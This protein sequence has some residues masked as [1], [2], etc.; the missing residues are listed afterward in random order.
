M[1][2]SILD[3]LLPLA[4]LALGVV[5]CYRVLCWFWSFSIERR[6]RLLL[7]RYDAHEGD[8]CEELEGEG[9]QAVGGGGPPVVRRRARNREAIA[10]SL[11][12]AAYYQ[13]GARPRSEANLLVTRKFMRDQLQEYKDLRAKDGGVIIDLAL[14]MS[15]L[16]SVE[17]RE[18]DDLS[19]TSAFGRRLPVGSLWSRLLGLGSA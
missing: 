19:G 3:S 12:E 13:F 14:P 17:Y 10:F 2:I 9:F 5:V 11:A 6:A 8:L 7:R 4:F 1:D 15:F 18:M 16:P